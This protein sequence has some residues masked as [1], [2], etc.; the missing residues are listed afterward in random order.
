MSKV[1]IPLT[2]KNIAANGYQKLDSGLIIQWGSFTKN[3]PSGGGTTNVPMYQGGTSV[4]F[5]IA[6]PNGVFSITI[7]PRDNAN[8]VLEYANVSGRN[9]TSFSSVHGGIQ[10]QGT[11]PATIDLTYDWIAIGN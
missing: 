7:T 4:N 10:N 3:V 1:L 8:V 9:L 2:D 11:V 5:P 6:F